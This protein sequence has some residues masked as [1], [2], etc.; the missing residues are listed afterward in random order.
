MS[1]FKRGDRQT[2]THI[3]AFINYIRVFVKQNLFGYTATKN[4]VSCGWNLPSKEK[5]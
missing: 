4:D 2:D 3:S 5:M 1:A